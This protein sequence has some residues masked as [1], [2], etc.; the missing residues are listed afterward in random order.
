M[1]RMPTLST[2]ESNFRP[3]FCSPGRKRPQ[4]DSWKI[5]SRK[6]M[7]LHLWNTSDFQIVLQKCIQNRKGWWEHELSRL[8]LWWV[9]RKGDNYFLASCFH[10]QYCCSVMQLYLCV[11]VSVKR[12]VACHTRL[13]WWMPT[14]LNFVRNNG[15]PQFFLKKI[16]EAV[17]WIIIHEN[18][19]LKWSWI[20]T[21]FIRASWFL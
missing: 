12:L 20:A 9:F 10:V 11:F 1:T 19:F 2:K 13:I 7:Y 3:T 17:N 6:E 4:V 8:H 18:L 15:F 14:Y 21:G 5:C 16:P